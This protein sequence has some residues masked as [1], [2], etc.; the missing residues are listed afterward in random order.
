[1]RRMISCLFLLAIV[2]LMPAYARTGVEKTI[3]SNG[4][5]LLVK[6]EPE[7]RIAAIEVFIR[8]GAAREDDSNSGI[9][10]LLAGTLLSGTEGRSPRK[11][12]QLFSQV[13]GNFHAVRQWDYIEIY[14][15]TLPEMCAD[16]VGL[17]SEA[18]RKPSF[19]SAAVERAKASLLKQSRTLQDNA[20]QAAY[21]ALVARMNG[22]GPYGGAFLGDPKVVEGV[23][24]AQ[25]EDFYRKKVTPGSIV[26][27]VVGNVNP[28]S[29]SRVVA[30]RFGGMD[31]APQREVA[32][33]YIPRADE[34]PEVEADLAASY[35]MVGFPAPPVTDKDYPA[36]CIANVLLGGNK[37]ALMFTR[38]REGQGLGYHVGSIYPMLKEAGHIAAFVGLDSSRGPDAGQAVKDQI[39]ALASELADGRFADDDVE[40]AKRYLIGSH[41]L[42]RERT[43]DR[44]RYLGIY[45][46]LGL[47]Y[48]YD[49]EYD[50]LVRAVSRTDL[51]RV[52][53]D[54]FSRPA[55]VVPVGP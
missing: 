9:G 21:Y 16:A 45:E 11:L 23:T 51:E 42:G 34:P 53:R 18:V 30:S 17:L 32:A 22:G 49:S 4:L 28:T 12:S 43:R 35:V 27:S 8:V 37:S 41:A 26:I 20:Y 38:L 31:Y 29:I 10:H 54:I 36:A 15:V 13:G 55:A 52:C 19:D 39:L 25:L 40:R 24:R 7:S 44:A 14:A 1:M 50:A 48:R 46:A 5:T 3:L 47:G 2:L 6:P 33:T